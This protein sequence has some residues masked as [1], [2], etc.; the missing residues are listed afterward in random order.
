VTIVRYRED[1]ANSFLQEYEATVLLGSS[2]TTY[3]SQ[4]SI[5]DRAPWEH[6]NAAAVEGVLSKFTG[7]ITQI[8]PVCDL[9]LP[10]C[11]SKLTNILDTL[12]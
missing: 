12:H 5:I 1:I 11:T 6:I 7:E 8:P 9:V 10:S 4:G 2:T 3:D